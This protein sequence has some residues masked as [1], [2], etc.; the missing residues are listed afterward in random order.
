MGI[1]FQ[2]NP[3]QQDPALSLPGS[4]RN[5][6]GRGRGVPASLCS[7]ASERSRLTGDMR[8]SSWHVL[9]PLLLCKAPTCNGRGFALAL[10]PS[11]TFPRRETHCPQR[12][13]RWPRVRKPSTSS[14][15]T[16]GGWHQQRHLRCKQAA[17][18]SSS[19]R[20]RRSSTR[21]AAASASLPTASSTGGLPS[22]DG[23]PGETAAETS[24]PPSNSGG[25]GGGRS[26]R[27]KYPVIELYRRDVGSGDAVSIVDSGGGTYSNDDD[28]IDGDLARGGLSRVKV[29]NRRQAPTAVNHLRSVLGL[30]SEQV[31]MMLESFPA[32]ADVPP[33]KLDLPAKLVSRGS[34]CAFPAGSSENMGG[35]LCLLLES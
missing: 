31:D 29:A 32:L 19:G 20:R 22:L 10:V 24:R 17:G 6:G 21:A 14:C 4:N 35:G 30:G 3:N 25:G 11:P 8:P 16:R 23:L 26:R 2:I 1:T 28:D 7:F 34:V 5:T 33:D 9:T 18:A 12:R 15:S 27:G 13:K